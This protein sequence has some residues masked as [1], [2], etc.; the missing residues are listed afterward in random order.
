MSLLNSHA[1]ESNISK[2]VIYSTDGT[3]NCDITGGFARLQYTESILENYLKLTVV[4][5]DTGFSVEK[6]GELVGTVEGL[7]L[8]SS[9]TVEVKIEDG[10]GNVLDFSINEDNP[11]RISRIRDASNTSVDSM[12]FTLDLV[13][14]EFFE[15]KFVDNRVDG[16]FSG[17]ISE[18]V[19][20][21]LTDYLKTEKKLD[22]EETMNSE[23]ITGNET[24]DD[25]FY[26]CTWL[27]KRCIPTTP[28]ANEKTAGFL[29]FETYDGYQ[30]KS[31][32]RLLD[33]NGRSYKKYV[34][35]NSTYCPPGYDGKILEAISKTDIDLSKK[36]MSGSYGTKIETFNYFNTA[37]EESI[38]SADSDDPAFSFAGTGLP[39]F[40]SEFY[41]TDGKFRPASLMNRMQPFGVTQNID[42]EK[43]KEKDYDV[44]SIEAQA[45][46]RYNQLYTSTM[47]ITIAGDFSHRAGDLI[48][49]DFPK[50]TSSK[51]STVSSRN[52]GIYMI[53]DLTH[54]ISARDGTFTKMNL[55]RD[56]FGRKP[57]Q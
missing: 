19:K 5:A 44:K 46:M 10:F 32:E 14:A 54:F 38:A 41:T 43:S 36:M 28:G 45:K 29:F 47:T 20:K 12:N 56:S 6:D 37:Y 27:G 8:S 22:I 35:N 1:R 30:F 39:Q 51:T 13:S 23:N 57:F 9:E 40:S 53:A 21:I 50:I 11:L 17:K 26:K 42:K 4:A 24:N 31:I 25:P 55:V 18:T 33:S 52:S 16:F 34:Y 7:D 48:Y 2:F 15:N 3:K 49:C